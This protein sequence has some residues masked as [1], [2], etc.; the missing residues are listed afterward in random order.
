MEIKKVVLKLNIHDDKD[1]QKA[2]KA[3]SSLTGINL[4]EVDM[5]ESKMTVIG[6][7]DPVD[8]VRK[9]KKQW[10]AQIVTVGPPMKKKEEEKVEKRDEQA[11]HFA[12]LVWLPRAHNPPLYYF[13]QTPDDYPSTCV[14]C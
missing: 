1:K 13:Y 5:K 12:E 4:M 11:K 7:A 2:M 14:I 8:V 6:E 3:V 9:L 10:N